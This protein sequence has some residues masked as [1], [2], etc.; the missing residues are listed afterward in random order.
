[1]FFTITLSLISSLIL[2][3]L[4]LSTQLSSQLSY[5]W[6][7]AVFSTTCVFVSAAYIASPG[8]SV[9]CVVL[10]MHLMLKSK[11]SHNRLKCPN[12]ASLC[13]NQDSCWI[14]GESHQHH[15]SYIHS[16]MSLLNVTMTT[17]QSSCWLYV[18]SFFRLATYCI[19]W[20]L[21][22]LSVAMRWLLILEATPKQASSG[23][24]HDLKGLQCPSFLSHLI[25]QKGW[26]LILH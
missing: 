23:K 25:Q 9:F 2:S 14:S 16:L 21:I 11:A 12:T 8:S 18:H 7:L 20:L 3:T 6:L 5:A 19:C 13:Q 26:A 22:F 24:L 17:L 1:M 4:K 15:H 10:Q